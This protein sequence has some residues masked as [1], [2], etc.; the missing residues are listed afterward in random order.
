MN[1]GLAT[2]S[3][4]PSLTDDDR[5]LLDRLRRHGATADAVVWDDPSIAWAS[6]DAVVL[7]STWDYH[8]RGPEFEAWLGR[9]DTAGVTLWN[10]TSLVRWNMHK[11]YLRSLAARGI[12][13]PPTEWVA[14]GDA[15]PLES[16]LRAHGWAD[17]VVKPAISAS[18]T[19]TWHTTPD[20]G[21]D[22]AR[23]ARLVSDRDVLVQMAVPEIRSEG[24][25][26]LVFIGGA[27]SHATIK[28]PRPGDFRVQVEHGGTADPGRPPASVVNA[29]RV[30]ADAL[31]RPWLYARVDGVATGAGFML[32]EVECI[33]PHL[34]LAHQDGAHE[35]FAQALLR[36]MEEKER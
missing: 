36:L 28:R 11:G 23:Y 25:W 27:F 21:A 29:G 4:Y 9:L 20:I 30:I 13:V 17:A 18:A 26:S 6:Y 33:E 8:L 2:S 16:V 5:P 34:F 7:R 14:R 10:P 12:M 22:A 35:R 24:E 1:V 19:E 3:A 15:R 32:M 31:Q